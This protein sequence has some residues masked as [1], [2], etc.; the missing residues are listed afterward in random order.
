MF[1]T[2][3][4]WIAF[5]LA[6]ITHFQAIIVI[7]DDHGS[8]TTRKLSESKARQNKYMDF[9][10]VDFSR[11]GFGYFFCL[12]FRVDRIVR[13]KS[14]K[15]DLVT[16]HSQ[17]ISSCCRVFFSCS[18]FP[19]L[20]FPGCSTHLIIMYNSLRSSTFLTK[21]TRFE[22][23]LMFYDQFKWIKHCVVLF[24]SFFLSSVF[25][26]AIDHESSEQRT[27]RHVHAACNRTMLCCS[28]QTCTTKRK[29]YVYKL[30]RTRW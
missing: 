21:I 28:L 30:I 26:A 5:A 6:S 27:E 1:P 25:C 11:I 4:E 29:T 16:R 10:F 22:W 15:A 13:R 19:L 7:H 14:R 3:F 24:L 9:F 23:S 8:I 20:S 18:F 2:I 17:K 12:T